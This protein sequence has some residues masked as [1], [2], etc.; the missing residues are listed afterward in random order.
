M[1]DE[2]PSSRVSS[3]VYLVEIPIKSNLLQPS[4]NP[5]VHKNHLKSSYE[6]KSNSII[7]LRYQDP[8][9]EQ[10]KIVEG[11]MPQIFLK[12]PGDETNNLFNV[13]YEFLKLG[14]HLNY[15]AEQ[16]LEKF[17]VPVGIQS[18]FFYVTIFTALITCSFAFKIVHEI[19]LFEKSKKI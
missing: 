6:I 14:L 2:L 4:L 12:C 8:S 16:T 13:E 5:S 3:L 18:S 9:L 17:T 15:E 10:Y 19:I 1:T 7:D 11:K